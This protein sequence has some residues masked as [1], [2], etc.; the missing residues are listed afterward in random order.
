MDWDDVRVFAVVA[1]AGGVNKAA[2]ILKVTP[3]MVSRRI[4]DLEARL[5]AKLFNRSA[6][7][8]TLTAAGEDVRDKAL[9]MQRFATAIEGSARDRDRKEEGPVSIA[10][11][12]GLTSYWIAPRAGEFL[13]LNPKIQLTL[14]CGFWSKESADGAADL[15][16]SADKTLARIEDLITP[17]GVLHYVFVASPKYLDIYGTP[18]SAASAAGDHRT[19]KHVA[20]TFQ[21]ETWSKRASAVEAL[22]T[23]SIETNSSGALVAAVVNGSGIATMPSYFCHLYPDLVMIEDTSQPIQLWLTV[24]H[25]VQHSLRV[26]RVVKW[27]ERMFDTKTNPWFRDEFVH[28]SAFAAEIAAVPSRKAREPAADQGEDDRRKV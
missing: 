15:I 8:M 11:P 16:I 13:N 1:D 19:L 10:A 18:K 26:Q 2:Q 14:D 22:S 23:F 28:P 20:Q 9:S 3:G 6:T 27:L 7:G 24:R 17:L 5:G 25:E 21:R 12:D 4:D